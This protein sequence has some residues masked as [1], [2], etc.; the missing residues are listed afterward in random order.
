MKVFITKYA[1]K[2]GIYEIDAKLD[3]DNV[4]YVYDTNKSNTIYIYSKPNWHETK[5]EAIERAEQMKLKKIKS[6]ERQI[7]KLKN[8]NWCNNGQTV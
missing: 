4:D 6:L 5:E 7:E 1:L 8:I 2:R 3:E